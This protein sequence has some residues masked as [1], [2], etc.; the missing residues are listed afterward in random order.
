MLH[1]DAFVLRAHIGDLAQLQRQPQRVE[2][3]TPHLTLGQNIA[4]LGEAIGFDAVVARAPVGDVRGGGGALQQLCTLVV[5][6]RLDFHDGAREPQPGAGVVRRRREDLAEHLHARA[7]IV[8][9]ECRVGFATQ[10]RDR[11]G[12]GAGIG[13]DLRLKRQRALG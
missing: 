12:W 13:L 7:E 5:V 9:G 11:N 1:A 8:F 10:L 3:G 2:R 6:R 4:E